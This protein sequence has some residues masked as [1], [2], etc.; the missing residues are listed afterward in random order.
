MHGALLREATTTSWLHFPSYL[1]FY[2]GRSGGAGRGGEDEGMLRGV[3]ADCRLTSSGVWLWYNRLDQT[4]LNE[5]TSGA[6]A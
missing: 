3:E 4:E 1:G 2:G 6:R 5:T